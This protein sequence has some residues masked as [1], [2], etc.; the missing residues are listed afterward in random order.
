MAL[1]RNAA[2]GEGRFQIGMAGCFCPE[3]LAGP[4]RLFRVCAV[5]HLGVPCKGGNDTVAVRLLPPCMASIVFFSGQ[6]RASTSMPVRPAC[7]L[8]AG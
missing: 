6:G 1:Y 2:A 5:R 7:L 8:A 3:A 4:A